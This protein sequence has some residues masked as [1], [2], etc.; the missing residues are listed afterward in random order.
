MQ[1]NQ[2]RTSEASELSDV[3][4]LPL[5]TASIHSRRFDGRYSFTEDTAYPQGSSGNAGHVERISPKE[6]EAEAPVYHQPRPRART[7][8]SRHPSIRRDDRKVKTLKSRSVSSLGPSHGKLLC[9]NNRYEIFLRKQER[10][11]SAN[12]QEKQENEASPQSRKASM[13]SHASKSQ[14]FPSHKSNEK[15]HAHGTPPRKWKWWKLVTVDKDPFHNEMSATGAGRET[16]E[17]P[18]SHGSHPLANSGNNDESYETSDLVDA[19]ERACIELSPSPVRPPVRRDKSSSQHTL[20]QCRH[21]D[22]ENMNSVSAVINMP[23]DGSADAVPTMPPTVD[24]GEQD[25]ETSMQNAQ[26]DV[27]SQGYGA[28]VEVRNGVSR[29]REARS[30]SGE[31]RRVKVVV[32]VED[33]MDSALGKVEIRPKRR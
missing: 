25:A 33:G 8:T 11:G 12:T 4:P 3:H 2:P 7:F 20:A 16:R 22:E 18:C 24:P 28:I 1:D 13:R 5:R 6:T 23:R 26:V 27:V 21:E 31:F 17:T 32:T 29:R 15:S 19:F 10:R 14:R 9:D 30:V